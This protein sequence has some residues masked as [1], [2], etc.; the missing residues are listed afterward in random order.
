MNNGSLTIS[1]SQFSDNSAFQGGV[2]N[3]L[4]EC[5]VR[6]CDSFFDHNVAG[7]EEVPQKAAGGVVSTGQ[8]CKLN[9][10][11][12]VFNNNKANIGGVLMISSE[13]ELTIFNSTFNRNQAI[14]GGVVSTYHCNLL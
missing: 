9:I 2:L 1:R 12:S 13:V 3:A 14:Q 6:I 7:S 4:Q 8:S 10:I 5:S 11:G